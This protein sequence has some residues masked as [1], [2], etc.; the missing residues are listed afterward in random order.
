MTPA[1]IRRVG[2]IH[3]E[4]AGVVL[5]CPGMSCSRWRNAAGTFEEKTRVCRG[6]DDCSDN[7]PLRDEEDGFRLTPDI[8]SRFVAQIESLR[9][10]MKPF[11]R[12]DYSDLDWV[13]CELLKVWI[14]QEEL[15]ENRHKSN[16]AA[17]IKALLQQNG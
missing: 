9:L 4:T 1:I 2:E 13:E 6:C 16:L 3:G 12:F 15:Y 10:E 17:I 14:R 8:E 7:P 11:P 5:R